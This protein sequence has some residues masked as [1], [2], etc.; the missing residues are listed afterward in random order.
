MVLVEDGNVEPGEEVKGE[1]RE[2]EPITKATPPDT[3]E[4]TMELEAASPPLIMIPMLNCPP[5]P[6]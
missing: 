5:T 3:K 4:S 2:V 1:P 6:K